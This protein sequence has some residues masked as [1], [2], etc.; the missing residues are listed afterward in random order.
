[1]SIPG[2]ASPL[3]IGAAA[4]AAAAGYQIDRSLRFNSADGA[5]LGKTFSSAGSTT[6]WTLSFWVKRATSGVNQAVFMAYDGS[7]I[8]EA[9]Y[10]NIQFNYN[11]QLVV[12]Y[13]YASYKTTNRRFRDF[14]SWYHI[15]IRLE[16]GNS[17][18]GDRVQIYVNGVKETSFASTHD[19]DSGQ[20]LAWNKAYIH[21]IGSEYNQQYSNC[22]FAEMHFVEQAL[23][24]TD[25]G[26]FDSD[27]NWNPKQFSGTYGTNGFYL[28]FADNSSNA[29]LGTD[30][31][32]NNNT[33]TTHNLTAG[34]NYG[35]T[36]AARIV[37]T[38]E[39]FSFP[40]TYTATLTYEFFVRI[41]TDGTYNHMARADGDVWNL[42]TSGSNL[43]FGNFNGGW[44]TFNSTGLNDSQWHFVRLTTTGSSTSLYVDGSLISTNYSG[45]SVSTGSQVTNTIRGTGSSVF[46][47]AHLRIT[48]GGT[49]PTTGIPSI[50]SMNAAAG[51]GGTL[52]FYDKLD[53]I[54]SSGTKTSD[55]GNVTI[56]MSAATVGVTDPSNDSLLDTPTN[57]DDGTNVGGNY[58]TLNPLHKGNNATLSNGNLSLI[59]TAWSTT[60]STIGV[61]SGKWYAEVTLTG[62]LTYPA[63]GV[64]SLNGAYT[65]SYFGQTADSFAWFAYQGGG[66]YTAGAYTNR[67]GDWNQSSAV[68]DVI[69]LALDMDNGTLKFYRNGN[70]LGGGNA[71]TGITG[72]QFFA[73]CGYP[74]RENW[75]FGQRA[76]AYPVS[77]YKSLCT[78][79]L[80]D[81][82]I[83]DGSTAFDVAT[84]VGNGTTNTAITGLNHSPDLLWIKSRSSTQ[85]HFLADT[86]RGNTK[87]LASNAADA[88]ET[89]TN[90]L[91]SFDSNGFTIGNNNTVNENNSNFV[92]WAWD[93][94]TST[95]SNTDG[96][97]TSQVRA[98]QTNGI[99]IVTFTGNGTASATV[100]HGLN[101][102]PSMM[103]LK[104]RDAALNWDFQAF[105]T[106]RMSLNLT[107]G[108]QGNGLSTFTSSTFSL[109]D[110]STTRNASGVDYLALLFSPV[111]GFSSMGSYQ[112]N[113]SADGPFV[114][115]GFKVNWLLV[116]RSDATQ[117]WVITDGVRNTSNI[118][119]RGLYADL[120]NSESTA[121]RFDFVSNGF[122]IR[123]NFLESNASGGTYIYL[124]FA[125]HPFKTARAR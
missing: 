16:T 10:A 72:T 37:G 56:T 7:S 41:T 36:T 21:R 65:T 5:Y 28:K 73:T 109:A 51:S 32:G 64:S 61:S 49:P 98:S 66:L 30:S 121:D 67:T 87:N 50:A 57:Y 102:A 90:R 101:A 81:P 125:E 114:Y 23:D 95:V 85:W 63:F 48:T 118:V 35:L 53:D 105:G 25:F 120:T 42:G 89:R 11:D 59:N 117:N 17:T 33:F 6:T 122:K 20:S 119:D 38:S 92:A 1:M 103:F 31:S 70:L 60:V 69:G 9:S 84:Y 26:E 45:G 43:L 108:N 80:P 82:T 34:A 77:G 97:I 14:S 29:A 104:N 96:S 94:G 115:T 3:F 13:A 24:P 112:G 19:P 58:A 2:S 15:V 52:A 68:G 54:A 74:Q 39:T 22:L 62:T 83:A 75:N 124:A 93:A 110:G 71:F 111:E 91:L 18:P 107:E 46:E 78:T 113:G 27:N 99:S 116:R 40:I 76:F 47:I 79:N 12:G 88:E 106:T 55:G 4:G 8:G 86:I 100:G 44:T 123:T